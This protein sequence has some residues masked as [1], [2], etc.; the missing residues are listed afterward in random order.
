MFTP[1]GTSHKQMSSNTPEFFFGGS[2]IP[3]ATRIPA[4]IPTMKGTGILKTKGFKRQ[5]NK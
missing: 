4:P 2:Q 3:S 1:I 5:G